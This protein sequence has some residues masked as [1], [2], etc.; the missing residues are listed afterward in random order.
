MWME[1]CCLIAWGGGRS[2]SS[3][4]MSGRSPQR[5]GMFRTAP[6]S[7]HTGAVLGV[8]QLYGQTWSLL[9]DIT[10]DLTC[11]SLSPGSRTC[12]INNERLVSKLIITET[13]EFRILWKM[14]W[15]QGLTICEREKILYFC[16]LKKCVF[17]CIGLSSP[18]TAQSKVFLRGGHLNLWMSWNMTRYSVTFFREMILS[19]NIPWNCKIKW[20]SSKNYKILFSWR[21]CMPG[22]CNWQNNICCSFYSFSLKKLFIENYFKTWCLHKAWAKGRLIGG[23]PR[24]QTHRNG[25][26]TFL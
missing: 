5:P 4:S 22:K 1:C 24:L 23:P 20:K 11:S 15:W 16:W 19:Q 7:L 3:L 25:R 21:L 17:L 10:R 9:L 18:D 12:C 26:E 6:A 8:L 14:I 2:S 13:R